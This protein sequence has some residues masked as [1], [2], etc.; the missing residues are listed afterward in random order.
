MFQYEFMQNAFIA[1]I[2]ISILCPLVGTFLV[3]KKIFND[4]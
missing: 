3:L 2:F 4:G 1:A